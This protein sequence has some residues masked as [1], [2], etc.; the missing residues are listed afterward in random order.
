[1][2]ALALG[3]GKLGATVWPAHAGAISVLGC[4][5]V[6]HH[7][8]D[9][10]QIKWEMDSSGKIVGRAKVRLPKGEFTHIAFF[11]T[12]TGPSF[13]GPPMQLD[14]PIKFDKPGILEVY[15]I[16]GPEPN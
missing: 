14:H 5:P 4:E 10:G 16:S 9:R 3:D 8:Y 11:H 6:N 1:M 13:A 2:S 12:P 7:D 15:P